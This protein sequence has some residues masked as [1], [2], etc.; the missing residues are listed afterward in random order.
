MGKFEKFL[1]TANAPKVA[2]LLKIVKLSVS[3]RTDIPDHVKQQILNMKIKDLI[4]S[5]RAWNLI[6][7]VIEHNAKLKAVMSMIFAQFF[8]V[9]F[10]G[11]LITVV[12]KLIPNSVVNRVSNVFKSKIEDLD[13]S[14]R[15]CLVSFLSN[16]NYLKQAI[17]VGIVPA[18]N[19]E[20]SKLIATL[21]GFPIM[22][23]TTF[24]VFEFL[25]NLGKGFQ[26]Y[27]MR[28]TEIEIKLRQY[29]DQQTAKEIVKSIKD[30][31]YKYIDKES[32]YPSVQIIA[33]LVTSGLNSNEAVKSLARRLILYRSLAVVM[34]YVCI[35]FHIKKKSYI[36]S[37]IHFFWNFIVGALVVCLTTKSDLTK[38]K[39]HLKKM[40]NQ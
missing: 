13:I 35:Y 24:N 14:V 12:L 20:G 31:V 23:T 18:I 1:L 16:S 7:Y 17:A 27:I 22:Y 37:L 2:V 19:E 34:H 8:D 15:K 32:D 36:S 6:S 5:K 21:A 28:L 30:L 33:D 4:N 38:L 10:N 9:L 25:G 40:E 29:F 26:L 3:G 11:L 39:Q